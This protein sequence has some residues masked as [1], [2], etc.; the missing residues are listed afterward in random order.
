LDRLRRDPRAARAAVQGAFLALCAWI[1]IEFA[2]F[3]RWGSS[4]GRALEVAH[5]PGAEGFLPIAAL[6]SLKHALL[7]GTVH[8]VHPA[9]LVILVAA[10]GLGLL[11]RK[12]FCAWIC[13]VGTI[14][15]V[16]GALGRR[17]LGRNLDP[18][19]W[20][21]LPLRGAKYLLLGFFLWA[22]W[23]MD[24]PALREFLDSPFNAMA[25]I[26]MY[27]FFAHLSGLGLGVLLALAVLS[28]VVRQFWCRYLC[29]YGALL[30]LL[31]LASPL[32]ITRRADTCI[33]CRKCTRAC[34]SR[35][36]VHAADRV[37]GA[38]CTACF[39]CVAA[40]PVKDTLRME[41]PGRRAI[42]GWVFGLLVA[43]FFAAVTGLAMLTGH[44]RS[45]LTR[46]DYLQLIPAAGAGGPSPDPRP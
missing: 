29:P 23:R 19:R 35:I 27:L 15:E 4:G 6:L 12:A 38:E 44:W 40:C 21:D 28:M 2:L 33:D 9:A 24:L 39:R 34:P 45:N 41:A 43:G 20:V 32:R 7:T 25:D 10:L 11:M 37:G 16:L 5:P 18:P 30:G 8:P 13:P 22:V 36:Q 3:M 42:Q 17:T 31:S 14:S 46:E 26:R 1:G